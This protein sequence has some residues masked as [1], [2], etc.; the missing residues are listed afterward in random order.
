MQQNVLSNTPQSLL[1]AKRNISYL[2]HAKYL[3]INGVLHLA[4]SS[5]DFSGYATATAANSVNHVI[6][7]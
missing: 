6:W 5:G 4:H 3:I 1:L 2:S 7:R